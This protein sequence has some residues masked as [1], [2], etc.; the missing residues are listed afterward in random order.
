[1]RILITGGA[2]FIGCNAA[3][4]F[5]R[6]GREVTVFDNFS[7]RGS[8]E[9]LDW[10][11][12]TGPVAVVEGDVRDPDAVRTVVNGTGPDVVL[13]L[14]AQV[15]VTTSLT[16]PRTDFEVNALG[17]LNVLEA[18]RQVRREAFLIYTSTNKVYGGLEP[19]GV[20]DAGRR[21]AFAGDGGGVDEQ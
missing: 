7:R 4:H 15:A 21:Y 5:L 12:E 14:A 2:G 6:C 1:M 11:R 8:R 13:H 18:L 19:R 16:D 20:V 3:R 17:T 10:I 9:N